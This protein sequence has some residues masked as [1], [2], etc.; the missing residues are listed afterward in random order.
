MK[1]NFSQQAK[2][3]ASF[4]PHYPSTL[5]EFLFKQGTNFDVALDC[6][7][8]NGQVAVVLAS[9]FKTVY[10]TD[11]SEKQLAQAPALSNVIYKIEAAEKTS[12]PDAFDLVTVAQA[13]HWFDFDKFYAEVKRVLK[14]GGIFA[15]IGYGLI[16]INTEIDKWIAHY[17]WNVVGPYWDKER[18]Y[19]DEAY[20]TI[21]FPFNEIPSPKLFIEYSW[22]K[23]QFIGYLHTWSSLQH[24]IKANNKSPLT[25]ELLQALDKV[26]KDDEILPVKFPLFVRMGR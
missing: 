10:A 19:I 3:Y 25:Y 9:K 6:A 5:Y 15:V 17:Y 1:D 13:I 23:E 21:P 24:Y 11:I 2:L 4:R 20:T 8:G 12:F 22:N 18:R 16:S 14:P 7:T 26:W